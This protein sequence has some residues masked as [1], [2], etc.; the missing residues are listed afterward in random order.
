MPKNEAEN[1]SK[2]ETPKNRH[3]KT[4][5]FSKS[6]IIKKKKSLERIESLR[7]KQQ[8][9]EYIIMKRSK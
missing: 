9:H 1:I 6:Q 7:K 4:D 2:P 8:Y 5:L 3:S